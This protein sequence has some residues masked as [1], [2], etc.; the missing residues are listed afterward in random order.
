MHHTFKRGMIAMHH[1]FKTWLPKDF[2]GLKILQAHLREKFV[3]GVLVY[4]G[5]DVV[6]FGKDLHAVPIQC[7]P[8][9]LGAA[10]TAGS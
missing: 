7:I 10:T 5:N 3:R 1:T 6:P 9:T 8:G 2:S 4:T